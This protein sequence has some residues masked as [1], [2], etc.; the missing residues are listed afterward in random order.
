M[1]N[2]FSCAP[3][4]WSDDSTRKPLNKINKTNYN[5]KDRKFKP[6]KTCQLLV[7]GIVNQFVPGFGQKNTGKC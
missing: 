7:Y 4:A 3:Y 5:Y 2:L 6:G 1:K